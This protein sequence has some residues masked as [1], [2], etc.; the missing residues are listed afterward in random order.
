TDQ[1][2]QDTL[3]VYGNDLMDTPHLD[4]VADESIVFDNAYVTQPV[5]T[6]SR[7]SI[8]TGLYPHTCGCT[9]NNIPLTRE[10]ETIA[11][12][13]PEEYATGYFG[14]WHLGDEV[15]A[16]HGFE[17][18]WVSTEEY[19]AH[20][21]RELYK[22]RH[23]SYYHFLKSHG[24]EPDSVGDDGFESFSRGFA[25]HLPKE[26]TKP[27]FTASRVCEFIE[28][29]QDEPFVAYVNFL[30]PHQPFHGPF[31]T[32]Y[33]PA[34]IEFSPTFMQH[35][36]EKTPLRVRLLQERLGRETEDFYR[37]VRAR[38]YGLVSLVDYYCGEILHTLRECG[39]YDDTIIVFTSDHGE[40]MG[41]HAL[42][43][44]TVL[45]E[46]AAQVPM[47]MRVPERGDEQMR[48]QDPV[49]QID[50]VPTL[51]ELM[52]SQP[53]EHLQGRSL[54]SPL[55]SGEQPAPRDVF[56]EWNGSNGFFTVEGTEWSLEEQ[57]EVGGAP[58]RT[59][60]T[61][62]GWKLT[63]RSE[64]LCELY[65]LNDDPHETQNL[66]GQP[67]VKA[68]V[69]DLTERIRRWQKQT[70]DTVSVT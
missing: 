51:M 26:L 38:Y 31:D 23:S 35:G 33:D 55:R 68:I 15:I 53:P 13:L 6:P 11:E 48:I 58:S 50:L 19:H 69:E 61:P 65:N 16:Q 39:L 9:E 3:Q 21:T 24:L 49:S 56:I 42:M 12:M 66:Y 27:A 20:K 52:G 8:M 47:F 22:T 1:Q 36:D 30:E 67:E 5:C 18:N 41:D 32:L 44:K 40:M 25:C 70:D 2:R 45:Y 28:S 46:E 37:D 4:A 60:V 14:K 7:S 34:D 17:K 29:S 43:Y 59:V 10:Y 64:D 63:L 57:E 54:A 62:D